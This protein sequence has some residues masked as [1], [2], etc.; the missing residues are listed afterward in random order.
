MDFAALKELL[1]ARFPTRSPQLQRAARY[2]LE[3]PEE[4]ALNSMRT[5]AAKGGVTPSPI[6]LT[7]LTP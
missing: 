6:V 5:I 7:T 1:E 3:H 2:V 4:I